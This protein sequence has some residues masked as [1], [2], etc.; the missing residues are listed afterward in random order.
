MLTTKEFKERIEELAAETE[1]KKTVDGKRIIV[2]QLGEVI[3]YVYENKRY[4]ITIFDRKELFLELFHVMTE[5]AQ[6]PIDKREK[7][8]YLWIKNVGQN[9]ESINTISHVLVYEEHKNIVFFATKNTANNLN[10]QTE[11]T[12][13][14]KEE[15]ERKTGVPLCWIDEE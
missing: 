12:K 6:T 13:S 5:Y 1:T 14:E 8:G 10:L 9:G 2:K 4:A 3:G 11:Y 15:I 7:K